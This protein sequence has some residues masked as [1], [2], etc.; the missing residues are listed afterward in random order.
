M[1]KK[2]KLYPLLNKSSSTQE[3]PQVNNH[4]S[5]NKIE[6]LPYLGAIIFIYF[7]NKCLC[8]KIIVISVYILP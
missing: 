4:Y 7:F 6:L 3:F 1:Y 8:Q 5:Q 2:N